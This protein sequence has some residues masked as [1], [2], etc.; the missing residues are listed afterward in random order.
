MAQ[1]MEG[2]ALDTGRLADSLEGLGDGIGAHTPYPAIEAPGD[3]IQ[4]RQRGC[5]KRHP[6]RCPGLRFRDQE[7]PGPA[8]QVVPAHG[9]DLP[10]T[11]GGFDG[12][13]DEGADLAAVGM[14][15]GEEAREFVVDEAAGAAIWELG[16][17]DHL[18]GVRERRHAPFSAGDIEEVGEE[19]EIQA[20]GIRSGPFRLPLLH[21]GRNILA[22]DA[23]HR[24][25]GQGAGLKPFHPA[26]FPIGILF[27]RHDLAGVSV[28]GFVEGGVFSLGAGDED[29]SPHLRF[30]TG[31]PGLGFCL[32]IKG[33]GLLR[34][35]PA[36]YQR[37]PDPFTARTR[38]LHE[39]RHATPPVC[40]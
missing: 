15:G 29:A 16:L 3:L 4:D 24:S 40:Y 20:D 5:G 2:Q 6:P 39:R 26:T 35:S 31:C 12:P 33:A 25:P 38:S 36:P 14:G 10:A 13:C 19:G 8:V 34:V 37:L 32:G 23:R 11:H 21:E 17:A 7:Y 30:D 9:R 28:Q 22:L 1:I 18:Y 27:A